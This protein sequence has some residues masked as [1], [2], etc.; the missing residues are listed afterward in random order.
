MENQWQ[1]WS[2]ILLNIVVGLC[3]FA[4]VGACTVF[5]LFLS[6]AREDIKALREQF[7]CLSASVTSLSHDVGALL[8]AQQRKEAKS[9]G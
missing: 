8:G 1:E 4:F 7:N 6:H 2:K 9:R 3:G 5:M